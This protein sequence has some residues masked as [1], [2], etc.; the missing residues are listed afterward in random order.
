MTSDL[1]QVAFVHNPTHSNEI[2]LI[3]KA[4]EAVMANLSVTKATALV[5]SLLELEGPL[6]QDDILSLAEEHGV[7]RNK[8]EQLLSESAVTGVIQDHIHFTRQVLQLEPGQTA[9]L[10]NGKVCVWVVDLL[11]II[12]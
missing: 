1:V 4:I 7:K 8:M 6:D 10:S 5:S 3:A 11:W 2:P 12:V 9:L